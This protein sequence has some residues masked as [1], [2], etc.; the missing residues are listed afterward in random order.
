MSKRLA[1][2]VGDYSGQD[3]TLS[4][5]LTEWSDA[6][7][8]HS[9]ACVDTSSNSPQRTATYM[10]GTTSR[11]LDFFDLLS[12]Q[13]W[14]HISV[15]ATR[16]APVIEL[17]PERIQTE[18]QILSQVKSAFAS[19]SQLVLRSATVSIVESTGLVASAF[20]PLWDAHLLQEP[21][22]RIDEAVASQP[23]R[24]EMRS[25]LVALL[26]ISAAGGFVWQTGPLIENL[27]DGAAGNY[28]PLRIARSFLR[29]VNAG[30][31][32]D[33]VLSGAFPASGPWSVPPDVPNLRA[34]PPST[35]VPEAVLADLVKASKF[36]Y[37]RWQRT[38]GDGPKSMGIL[39]GIKLFF[40]EFVDALAS[41]PKSLVVSMKAEAQDWVQNA[42]FGKGSDVLLKFNVDD[43][44]FDPS[45]IVN[46]VQSQ[47]LGDSIEAIG[48][49]RPWEIL[50]QTVLGLIDGGSLPT[51]ISE[52][53]SGSHRLIFTEPNAVGPSPS[54]ESFSITEFEMNVLGLEGEKSIIETMD[55]QAIRS[56]DLRLKKIDADLI[57]IAES[58]KVNSK[59]STSPKAATDKVVAPAVESKNELEKTKKR[60]LL[61]RIFGLSKLTKILKRLRRK[62]KAVKQE[63]GDNEKAKETEADT[64]EVATDSEIPE[65]TDGS[66]ESVAD[67]VEVAE[68]VAPTLNFSEAELNPKDYMMLTSYYQGLKSAI[69][70]EYSAEMAIYESAMNSYKPITGYWTLKKGCDHCGTNFDHGILLLHEPTK[71]LLHVGRQ[72][73]QKH[74]A[75]HN[76][77]DLVAIRLAE[78]KTRY[79][80]WRGE[81]SNSLLF[82]IGMKIVE[83]RV[84]AERDL[85]ASLEFLATKPEIAEAQSKARKK[86]RKWTRR[87]GL[88]FILLIAASIASI[89]LTPLPLLLLAG[90]MASSG[91]GFVLRLVFL[92]RDIVRARFRLVQASD[93]FDRAFEIGRNA[94]NETVRMVSVYEQFSDWQ[95]IIRELIHIPFGREVAFSG[96]KIGVSEVRRPPA[97]ILGQAQPDDSQKMRMYLNARSQTIHSGW[98]TEIMDV[99]K[100]EWASDYQN[101]RLTGPGDNIHP[102]G[103][104][105]PSGSVVGKRPMS[106]DDVY[107]PRTDFRVQL[108]KGRLQRKLVDRKSHQIAADLGS[109]PINSL[110]GNVNVPGL[111]SALSG[112]SVEEFLS[113]LSSPSLEP[114]PF[115][116]DIFSGLYPEYRISVPALTLPDYSA[117]SP[118]LGHIQVEPGMEFTAAAWRIELSAPIAPIEA[119]AGYVE[120]NAPETLIS[121]PGEQIA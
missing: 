51:E 76:Q 119:F 70:D 10:D 1:I 18:L 108:L 100:S 94:A 89:V 4:T 115:L 60:G 59:E 24:D 42:T 44:D 99:L 116:S 11:S 40:K 104:N 68:E 64:E 67:A 37:T 107:Y 105:A 93:A 5:I 54:G 25:P 86:F 41:I 38:K 15:I 57:S 26:A 82:R 90:I 110:L 118:S 46:F 35:V 49:A 71:E 88:F 61:S 65:V 79:E 80:K 2:I 8:L 13:I 55:I 96:A 106:N 75:V 101:A 111:G 12:S 47:G 84:A 14:D 98:L 6:G 62:P 22:I 73:A 58:A 56:L 17:T 39:D 121:N 72:C 85:V 32:T 3:E 117:V 78:L 113:G 87:G 114:I 63:V 103:D 109:T 97:F 69:K 95:V 81:Q 91:S 27:Q 83:E 43:P 23:L 53:K 28:K 92:A 74:F 31:L 33:D 20:N 19:H 36:S 77:Q 9:V 45:E 30:R 29:V 102:E 16:G 52:P 120:P 66:E 21:V 7:I 34:V 50:Q 48:D 112:Q